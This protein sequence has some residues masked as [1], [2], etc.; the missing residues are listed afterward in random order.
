M[1]HTDFYTA[2][3]ILFFYEEKHSMHMSNILGAHIEADLK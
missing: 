2:L 1:I 3:V